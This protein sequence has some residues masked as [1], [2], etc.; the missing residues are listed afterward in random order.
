MLGKLIPIGIKRLI[1][2]EQRSWLRVLGALTVVAVAVAIAGWNLRSVWLSDASGALLAG[3]YFECQI[4]PCN[5]LSDTLAALF[6]VLIG[7]ILFRVWWRR[8][9]IRYYQRLARQHPE[10]LFDAPPQGVD[11]RAVRG[12]KQLVR[13]VA[14]GLR[15]GD[16]ARPHLVQGEPGSGKSTFLLHLAKRLAD[17]GALPIV[18]SLRGRPPGV[19]VRRLARAKFISLIDDQ[20]SRQDQADQVW[21]HI[22]R[23]RSFVVL[24]DGLDELTAGSAY[25][26]DEAARLVLQ[27]VQQDVTLKCVF[28]ARPEAVPPS[29]D[30]AAWNLPALGSGDA[31]EYVIRRVERKGRTLIEDEHNRPLEKLVDA[32][33]LGASPFYLNVLAALFGQDLD[34][35]V[36]LSGWVTEGL[37]TAAANAQREQLRVALLDRYVVELASRD[38]SF[39]T[40]MPR[41][42]RIEVT[43]GLMA[44]A[45]ALLL[46]N[47]LSMPRHEIQSALA[48]LP[49]ALRV[50][51]PLAAIE[52][53]DRLGLTK[54]VTGPEGLQVRFSHA[55]VQAHLASRALEIA[56]EQLLPLLVSRSYTAELA[57]ALSMFCARG[58]NRERS[59][60]V[61]NWLL[62]RARHS[63][64]QP[65]SDAENVPAE[66][67]LALVTA[68][69]EVANA[70]EFE[71]LDRPIA[72]VARDVWPQ[73]ARGAKLA[74]I[75]SIDELDDPEGRR[76][77]WEWATEDEYWIRREAASALAKGGLRA[78]LDLDDEVVDRLKWGASTRA[79]TDWDEPHTRALAML[80]WILPSWF[81]AAA[82]AGE[83]VPAIGNHIASF[84]ALARNE[85]VPA[86]VEAGLAQGF[87]LALAD[88]VG[89]SND[90]GLDELERALVESAHETR[91]WYSRLT[92][93]QA[94]AR[95]YS[96]EADTRRRGAA[97]RLQEVADPDG[98]ASECHPFVAQALALCNRSLSS[99]GRGP[100]IEEV[101]WDDEYKVIAGRDAGI[102]PDA[103]ELVADVALVLNLA[104]QPGRP[105]GQTNDALARTDLPACI[106]SSE[107][108]E[109]LAEGKQVVTR[110][111]DGKCCDL[112]LCPYPRPGLAV[113]RGEFSETF[114]RR[115]RSLV[116]R[117]RI[118]L[119]GNRRPPWQKRLPIGS[120]KK[121]WTE[122][123][124]RSRA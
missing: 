39:K 108:R 5:L 49:E 103:R 35:V 56:P 116:G 6:V 89:S 111:T 30:F 104:E 102:G 31:L 55:I 4:F 69:A 47:A 20:V 95:L 24:A 60:A 76:T 50:A 90:D 22:S 14:D 9:A 87:K 75:S 105:V 117:R 97:D 27:T 29:P 80:G 123:E 2:S 53:G 113:A 85:H 48:E 115:Q 3:L 107:K 43:Q 92:Y 67:R 42:A 23:E 12:R 63:S 18:V 10:K 106:A 124:K 91:L 114:C 98:G 33:E 57:L 54:T 25:E 74:A 99:R 71:D 94:L 34:Y 72:K 37:D 81:R 15:E 66:R 121:F 86:R 100:A 122:M 110:R 65:A 120:L 16:R 70:A 8:R 51:D 45:C 88:R 38:A 77:L 28:T 58:R 84:R 62:H 1:W 19:D 109:E 93:V 118:P 78:Y 52:G 119:V 79:A 96:R 44:T 64:D 26:R 17:R 73:A 68:A 36:L 41:S 46:R 7:V 40:S 83:H 101:T 13:D 21:R 59:E 112:N 82:S 61:C 32:G 11:S